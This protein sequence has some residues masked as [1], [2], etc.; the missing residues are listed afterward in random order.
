M[1]ILLLSAFVM[2]KRMFHYD[3][4]DRIMLALAGVS[5]VVSRGHRRLCYLGIA[6]IGLNTDRHARISK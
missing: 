2:H 1:R 6:L 4:A 3:R 5:D